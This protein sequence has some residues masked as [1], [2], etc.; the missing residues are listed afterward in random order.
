MNV[1]VEIISLMIELSD[2]SFQEAVD[3]LRVDKK[4]SKRFVELL[5]DFT[6]EQRKIR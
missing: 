6:S 1:I 3:N 4:L 5:I 2:V